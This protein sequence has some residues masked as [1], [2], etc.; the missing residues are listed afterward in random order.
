MLAAGDVATA[1]AWNVITNDILQFA[2]F[3]QGVFTNEAARDAAITS[4]TEGMHIYLTA[5]TVPSAT[6][7][8][9]TGIR[10]V[11][12]G[13]NWVTVSPIMGVVAATEQNTSATYAAMTTPGPV[14][15]VQ[16][17]TS[18]LVTVS[19]RISSAVATRYGYAGFS[20][21]GATTIAAADTSAVVA[22]SSNAEITVDVS[23]SFYVTLNAG[24]NIFTMLYRRDV[25]N[26]SLGIRSL[27][28]RGLA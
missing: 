7:A 28:V 5:P 21:S 19:A 13:A 10:Q 4:P 18:A 1:A 20:V 3:V 26:T 14:V 23:N 25:N 24:T 15:Q 22:G 6:G 9:I 11:H 2:P 8:T 17:G 12:N 27:T 16:T